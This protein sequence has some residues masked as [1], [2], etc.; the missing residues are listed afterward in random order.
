MIGL[1]PFFFK[2]GSDFSQESFLFLVACLVI[3][4]IFGCF[5]S[6]GPFVIFVISRRSSLTP[7]VH[8]LRSSY[9]PSE[10]KIDGGEPQEVGCGEYLFQNYF[11]FIFSCNC[12]RNIYGGAPQGVEWGNI[13]KIV[14]LLELCVD[15][16]FSEHCYLD[17]IGCIFLLSF[18]NAFCSI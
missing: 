4:R 5:S 11:H 2:I 7:A 9:F 12:N 10:A 6:T 17:S 8:Y 1:Q 13:S 3:L 14:L 15:L 18:L 16:L